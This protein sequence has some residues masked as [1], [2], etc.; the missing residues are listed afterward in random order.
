MIATPL[1]YTVKQLFYDKNI[2]FERKKTFR[3]S[4]FRIVKALKG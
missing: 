3:Y 1:I 2:M 4:E